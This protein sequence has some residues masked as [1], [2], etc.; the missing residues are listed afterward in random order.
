MPV[1]AKPLFRPDVLRSHVSGFPPPSVDAAKLEHW[2]DL[3][4]TGRVDAFGEQEILDVRAR[5]GLH[6]GYSIAHAGTLKIC[7]FQF[8]QKARICNSSS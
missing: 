2:A 6:R 4:A 7:S 3:I 8:E 5:Y 1:E